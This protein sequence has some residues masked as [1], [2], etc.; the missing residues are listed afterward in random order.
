MIKILTITF[1]LVSYTSN[2]LANKYAILPK[3]QES[4]VFYEEKGRKIW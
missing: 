3:E 4:V 2:P 1:W